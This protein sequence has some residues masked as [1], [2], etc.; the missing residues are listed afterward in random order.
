ML[1]FLSLASFGASAWVAYAIWLRPVLR[2]RPSLRHLYAHSDSLWAAIRQKFL[3]I[4][5]QIAAALLKIAGA[6]LA[7]REALLPVADTVDWGPLTERIPTW[8]LPLI[9]F[10]FGVI[11][12]WL[13]NAT[14][15]EQL[16]TA[17]V[18]AD[19]ENV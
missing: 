10:G 1:L 13:R 7:I 8:T 19:S 5:T 12:L 11:L 6:L 3:F 14:A 18:K 15:K 9:A 2:Q 4:K 16:A 17:V